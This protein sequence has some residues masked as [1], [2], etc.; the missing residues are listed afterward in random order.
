[1]TYIKKQVAL[2]WK[3]IFQM[4]DKAAN[5]EFCAGHTA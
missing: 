1:M 4:P 5:A 3:H 2:I